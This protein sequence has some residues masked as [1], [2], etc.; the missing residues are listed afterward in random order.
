M[1]VS[2]SKQGT[3]LPASV[4]YHHS[5]KIMHRGHQPP[6]ISQSSSGN[7]CTYLLPITRTLLGHSKVIVLPG[8]CTWWWP[9][10]GWRRWRRGRR[11]PPGVCGGGRGPVPTPQLPARGQHPHIPG[12]GIVHSI[13]S[14]LLYLSH[15]PTR[16]VQSWKIIQD[17]S[18]RQ[19]RYIE[20]KGVKI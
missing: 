1:R 15:I 12:C 4:P 8:P 16:K 10:R 19:L 7:L 18:Q 20:W 9:W 5:L 6:A 11:G 17:I 13:I 2:G 3:K 14:T